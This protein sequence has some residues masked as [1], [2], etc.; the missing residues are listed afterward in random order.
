MLTSI[1]F[2][3]MESNA[4]RMAPGVSLGDHLRV[5]S[6]MIADLPRA[7]NVLTEDQKIIGVLRSLPDSWR[8]NN[9]DIK[10]FKDMSH[11]LELEAKRVQVKVTRQAL[12][13]K[14]WSRS[15]RG[16]NGNVRTTMEAQKEQ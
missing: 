9:G 6:S 1:N 5:M 2:E 14:Q 11:H 4:Y 8:T 16:P 7:G 13:V 10:A 3:P 15:F 12:F